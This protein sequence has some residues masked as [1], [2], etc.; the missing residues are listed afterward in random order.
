MSEIR[1]ITEFSALLIVKSCLPPT[2]ILKQI[3]NE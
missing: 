2:A 1:K 3:S